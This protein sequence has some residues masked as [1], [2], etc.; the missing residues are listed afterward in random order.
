MKLLAKLSNKLPKRIKKIDVQR[1][2]FKAKKGHI[3]DVYEA[4][5][6]DDLFFLGAR[7]LSDAALAIEQNDLKR[8]FLEAQSLS[9]LGTLIASRLEIKR[10]STG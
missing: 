9:N 1:P 3:N 10:T 8:A 5:S 7:S 4:G 2:D 6:I